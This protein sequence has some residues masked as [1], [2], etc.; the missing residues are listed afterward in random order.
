[1]SDTSNF[2]LL[3]RRFTLM[4]ILFLLVPIITW[5]IGWQ[6]TADQKYHTL[7]DPLLFLITETGSAPIYAAL[8]SLILAILLSMMC[9]KAQH[10]WVL[11]FLSVFLLHAG[12]QVIKS[13]LKVIYQEPRPYMS[14]MVEK[15]VELEPFYEESR[16]ERGLIIAENLLEE[17]HTPSYLQHHW[18][19]ET[20]F[21]F[22]SGHT[23]FA[24]TWAFIFVGFLTR[25]RHFKSRM[26]MGAISLWAILMMISRLRFGMHYPIDLLTSTIF[27]YIISLFFFYYLAKR[28]TVVDDAFLAGEPENPF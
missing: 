1:M 27:A 3:F 10:H 19:S 5:A 12:T 14:Y 13:S 24:V 26:V 28:D 25:E 18:E 22:P 2:K 20:G 8:V 21:S 6:W 7:L 15:G 9:K 16:R 4:F 23:I 17:K 11:I